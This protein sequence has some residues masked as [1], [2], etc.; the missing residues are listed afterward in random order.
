MDNEPSYEIPEIPRPFAQL[1]GD[2]KLR[3]AIRFSDATSLDSASFLE[4]IN[5]L[6]SGAMVDRDR[7][8]YLERST[9]EG[10]VPNE[11]RAPDNITSPTSGILIVKD[12]NWN[13]IDTVYLSNRDTSS[14][15]HAGAYVV[16]TRINGQFRPIWVS[17]TTC[18]C[19]PRS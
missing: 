11:I 19:C 1:E 2:I 8:T 5:V 10:Y 6:E 16:A 15:I 9:V 14:F 7:I 4:N 13:N 17:A 12:K 18:D 3:G